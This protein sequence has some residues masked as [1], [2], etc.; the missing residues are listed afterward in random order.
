MVIVLNDAIRT[1]LKQH[2]IEQD[3]ASTELSRMIEK[4][5]DYIS[6]LENGRIKKISRE[7]LL[8]I[9]KIVFNVDDFEADQNLKAMLG[10][11]NVI[12]HNNTILSKSDTIIE[13]Y[14]DKIASFLREYHKANGV[15][16]VALSSSIEYC[17]TYDIDFTSNVFRLLYVALVEGDLTEDEKKRIY[18]GI[19]QSILNVLYTNDEKPLD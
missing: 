16:A 6:Q 17:L 1:K 14:I 7:D 15:S 13:L 2:R 4:R 12:E 10:T 18:T 11:Q 3:I 8:A 9:I 19:K 5:R